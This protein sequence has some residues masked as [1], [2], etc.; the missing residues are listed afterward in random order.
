ME[1]A[2]LQNQVE[3]WQ[4]YV[5]GLQKLSQLWAKPLQ[6]SLEIASRSALGDRS[7]AMELTNL[8]WDI[9]ENTFGSFLLSPSLGYTREFNHKLLKAFDTWINFYKA[10]FDYQLVL[11]DIW[12]RAFEELMRELASSEEKDETVQNWRQFLQVWSSVFD[13]VFAQTFR[14]K[15]TLEI[16][17][18]FLKSAMTYRLHQQQLME[19]FL[20]MNDLP[21]RS[22]V[23]EIHRSIYE[24]RKEV[25]SL[26]KALAES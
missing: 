14:S 13:Q 3:L 15:H 7:A 19:V 2:T 12:V 9:Y 5:K 6:Q 11:L 26:K 17:G 4:L 8:Y 22:E 23:D 20:K 1:R 24:L 25:K 18:K 21:V 16:R 10:S